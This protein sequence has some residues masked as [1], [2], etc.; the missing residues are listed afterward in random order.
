[1][2]YPSI[3]LK[4]LA[5][6]TPS[7]H[8]VELIDERCKKINFTKQYDLVGISSLTYNAPRAY[9]IADEFRM[10]GLTVVLGGYHPTAL[11]TEAKQHADSVVMGEAE[12]TWPQLL[13]DFGKGKLKPFYAS[14]EPTDPKN[15]PPADHSIGVNTPFIDS[16]QATRGCPNNCQFCAIRNIEGRVLRARPIKK[17]MDEIES[18]RKKYLFF[19]DAS[20]TIN[21]SY[22]KSLFKEMKELNKKFDCCGNINILAEDGEFLKL[23]S[24]AG[25]RLIQVGFESI[26]QKSIDTISKN[27]K[28]KNYEKAVKKIEDYGIMVMG[29][30]M[31]GFDTDTPDIFDKTLDAI[32]KWKLD[33]ARF[34]ILTPFPGTPLYNKLE[35]ENRILTRNWSKYNIQKVVFKPKSMSMDQLSNGIKELVEEFHSISNSFKRSFNDSDFNLNQFITKNLRDFSAK[36]YYKTLGGF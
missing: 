10:R 31:F 24:E 36:H 33:R 16:I 32:Y 17:V 35:A 15:I 8:S 4:Q 9:K 2:S 1:M 21:P 22:S 14:K 11:P 26:S 12:S 27:N 28:V 30:F 20:L 18:I 7:E 6:I 19:A 29:L 23:A 13:D 5:A 3:T 34:S 25:C